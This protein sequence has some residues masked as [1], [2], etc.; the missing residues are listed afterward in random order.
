MEEY[1][2][3][4]A[5]RDSR[6]NMIFEGTNEILRVLVA[7]SG[8]RERRARTSRRSARALKAPLHLVRRP[9]GLRGAEDPRLRDAGQA[10]RGSPPELAAEGELVCK[11][12]APRP[13]P[14]RRCCASTARASSSKEY[15]QERLA[16]VAIDLYG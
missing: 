12:A 9:V 5:L 13:A 15:H 16:N 7:L 4:K 14:S 2:Y 6:V 8:M 11:Y 1:P 10:R 3:E